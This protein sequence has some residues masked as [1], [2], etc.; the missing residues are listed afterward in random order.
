MVQPI[1]VAALN[2]Y[3]KNLI[4]GDAY[5]QALYVKGE[6]SNLKMHTS[7]HI[8]LS[9]KDE[10]AA[11]RAVM[12]RT[13]AQTLRFTPTNGMKVV[14]MG[15]ASMYERDG[16]YQLYIEHMQADGIGDLHVAYEQLKLKLEQTGVFDTAHKK[17]IPAMPLVV[18]VI[19]SPTG[20]AVRD[21]C[22]VVS[23]RYPLCE[24]LICPVLVQGEGA[25]ADIVGAIEYMN[26]ERLADVLIVGR[27]GGSIEDLWAFNEEATVMAVYN[28][29]IPVISAV[30]HETDFTLCDFA[31][32]L[33]APTP[34]AA[35]E[36]SVPS[37]QA[38]LEGLRATYRRMVTLTQHAVNVRKQTLQRVTVRTPMD[39]VN[40]NRQRAD[41]ITRALY[42][43][44]GAAIERRQARYRLVTEKLYSPLLLSGLNKKR[45]RFSVAVAR[46][47]PLS[48]LSA[49]SRGYA[50]AQ[51]DGAVLRTV[52]QVK[53]GDRV[54][55]T[56][57]DG[58]VDATVQKVNPRT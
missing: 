28:S 20:A 11:V 34:S 50:V 4:E 26:R 32:D 25:S 21:I 38:L 27:G 57:T 55:I 52:S 6:I 18:G 24:I 44:Y 2:K 43:A 19:T 40:Q 3:V 39:Y 23:R 41:I 54:N 13:A 58:T 31:A 7:G 30:G 49:L 16:S 36:L 47:E 17:P 53:A 10:N 8:Y 46:L 29:A 15:K 22:N 5:T 14:I 33:R 56:L 35:A 51:S 37:T 42:M 45:E 9:L 48:P 12:F 1:T